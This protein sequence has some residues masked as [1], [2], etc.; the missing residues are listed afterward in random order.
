MINKFT[1]I[2]H[3]LILNSIKK[4][5]GSLKEWSTYSATSDVVLGRAGGED[6]E[7]TL[8]GEGCIFMLQLL[9]KVIILSLLKLW[10]FKIKNDIV[11]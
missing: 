11:S 3:V 8:E 5:H 7:A 6:D 2:D 1:K 4:C 9:D 10:L